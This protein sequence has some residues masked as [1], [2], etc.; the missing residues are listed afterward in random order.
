MTTFKENT[1]VLI[2]FSLERRPF[3]LPQKQPWV[4]VCFI[5]SWT[6]FYEFT[7]MF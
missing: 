4:P 5:F 1:E 3:S 2:N 6:S 7:C